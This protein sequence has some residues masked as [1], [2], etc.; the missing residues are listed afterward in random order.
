MRELSAGV[1]NLLKGTRQQAMPVQVFLDKL[2]KSDHNLEANLSTIFQSVRGSK[3]YWFLRSSEVRC[4]LREWGTPTLFLTFSC[5][6][7]EC[8]VIANYLHKVNNVPQNYPIGKLCCEDPISVS[9]KFSQKF[10][11]FFN[12]VLLKGRVLG[13]VTHYFFKKEYQARGASHYHAVVWIED[14]PVVGKDPPENVMSWIKERITCRIPEVSTNPELHRLVTKYQ[15][16]KCSGYCKRT[17]KYATA[18][19]TR[20]KFGFPRQVSENGELS[21]VDEALKSKKKIYLLPRLESE[22]RINDYNPLLLL[23]WKANMDIQFIAEQ[24]LALAHYVT[25]YITKAERSN[26]QDIWNEVASEKSIYS[27]LFSFGV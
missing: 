13:C 23:L 22:T 20:C 10:H 6:E 12:T 14:T 11:A 4:M 27:R 7:Y 26:M 25:G 1:Y 24:S 15:R 17:K 9:R 21:S 5:S 19:V 2:S 16:H 18:F 3:Q 8:P